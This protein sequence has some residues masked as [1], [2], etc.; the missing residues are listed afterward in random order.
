MSGVTART[1]RYYHEIGLL[2]PA[3]IGGNGYRYYEQSQLL[4]LQE[5]LLLRELGLDLARIGQVLA[6]ERDKVEA[7]CRHH[8]RLVAERDRLDQLVQTVAATIE[9][10]RE[11][12]A[13]AAEKM[14]EGFRFSE[15]LDELEAQQIE[16]TGEGSPYY[17]QIRAA[18]SD[19]DEPD[20]RRFEQDGAQVERRVLELLRAGVPCDDEAVFAVLDED[21][22]VQRQMVTLD[23]DSYAKLGE[24]FVVTP[25][26][27]AHFDAQDLRLAEYLRDAM[28]VYARTRME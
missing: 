17:D 21:L 7:L 28:A 24:A 2:P 19:W 16:R 14:F 25:Q 13:M 26:L 23:A 6:G 8:E 1:L 11:G 12:T 10:L 5:I 20:F 27:R 9:S 22:A 4:Q 3:R 18:I 15:M